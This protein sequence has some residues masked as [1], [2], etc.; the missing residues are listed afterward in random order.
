MLPPAVNAKRSLQPNTSA[1]RGHR[2]RR[3]PCHRPGCISHSQATTASLLL[4]TLAS[5]AI[6]CASLAADRVVQPLLVPSSFS[7]ISHVLQPHPPATTMLSSCQP[8]PSKPPSPDLVRGGGGRGADPPPG[9]GGSA[10]PTT[11]TTSPRTRHVP[12]RLS[13]R[14]GLS[15]GLFSPL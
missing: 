6:R 11:L 9:R 5:A 15:L 8:E 7:I 10:A 4:P 12:L 14:G 3:P 1:S 2:L 13:R